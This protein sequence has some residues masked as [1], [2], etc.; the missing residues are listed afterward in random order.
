MKEFIVKDKSGRSAKPY[1]LDIDHIKRKF[2]LSETDWNDEMSLLEFLDE[3][4]IGDTWNTDNLKI[5][6]INHTKT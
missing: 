2:D 5:E 1:K 4:E 3:S 6:C